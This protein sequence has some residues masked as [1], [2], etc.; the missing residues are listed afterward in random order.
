MTAVYIRESRLTPTL[1]I[2]ALI[3][4]LILHKLADGTKLNRRSGIVVSVSAP[5]SHQFC[6][7]SMH[8]LFEQENRT[9]GVVGYSVVFSFLLSAQY[10]DIWITGYIPF[11]QPPKLSLRLSL[12]PS[13][14]LPVIISGA[15]INLICALVNVLTLPVS[16]CA[17]PNC[18]TSHNITPGLTL[19]QSCTVWYNT[20][21]T[22]KERNHESRL[23]KCFTELRSGSVVCILFSP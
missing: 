19:Y 1:T 8:Q 17:F 3:S 15:L 13:A 14:I 2:I 11:R 5:T 12:S 21:R 23:L 16:K 6:C 20:T 4:A 10:S 22:Q 9:V 18:C 7:N